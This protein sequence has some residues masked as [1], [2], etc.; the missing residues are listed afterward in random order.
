MT[1]QKEQVDPLAWAIAYE[2]EIAMAAMATL[3][4]H[5]AMLDAATFLELRPLLLKPIPAGFVKTVGVT[6]GKPYESTGVSSLQ[7]Q[8]ERMD[9]VLTPMGWRERCTFNEDGTLCHTVIEVGAADAPLFT[10]ESYGGVDRGSTKGN[11]FKGSRT[12]AGKLA[13]ALV[14]P[15]HEIYL[16]AA[17]LDPD[18]NQQIAEHEVKPTGKP[19]SHTN[20]GPS[21]AG[22]L[23]DR[24]WK[25]PAA[26][27]ALQ[28]AASHAADRDIGDCSTQEAAVEGLAG[29][30]YDQAEKFDRW[31]VRKETEAEVDA[32]ADLGDGDE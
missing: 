9:N 24:A 29:L 20:I 16:G 21:I 15:G 18:V 30:N 13:L 23:V 4:A 1:A 32:P 17:D 11:I 7:V 3:K 2:A 10:R 14:G 28:L 26:K 8:I 22:K 5:D 27:N 19:A 6:K 25:V 31:L 12:N